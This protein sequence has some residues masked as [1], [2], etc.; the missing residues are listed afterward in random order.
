MYMLH[1]SVT[2]AGTAHAFERYIFHALATC[3]REFNELTLWNEAVEANLGSAWAR[4]IEL[5]DRSSQIRR[6]WLMYAAGCADAF[7]K[8]IFVTDGLTQLLLGFLVTSRVLTWYRRL[9]DHPFPGSSSSSKDL[10]LQEIRP[11]QLHFHILL[12]I[13][14]TVADFVWAYYLGSAQYRPAESVTQFWQRH[15]SLMIPDAKGRLCIPYPPIAEIIQI[16]ARLPCSE[17]G[18]E[19]AFS[20][21]GLIFGDHRRSIRDDL[22]EALLIIR[23]HGI[24]NGQGASDSLDKIPGWGSSGM[25]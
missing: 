10:I 19:R 18:V 7:L 2:G 5:F 3:L 12:S 13:D 21:L 25:K 24:P 23:L 4:I 11:L 9:P 17:A 16:D 22:A 8:R 14:E 1:S 20:R 6:N 15:Q